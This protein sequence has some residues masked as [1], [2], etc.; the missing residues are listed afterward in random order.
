M[1]YE[2]Q[3]RAMKKWQEN[4]REHINEYNKKWRD[5][6]EEYRIKQI[7][8]LKAHRLRKKLGDEFYALCCIEIF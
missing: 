3:K 7:G 8:Y 5:N 6:N 4:H 1:T 2:S